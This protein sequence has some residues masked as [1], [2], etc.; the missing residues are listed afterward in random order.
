MLPNFNIEKQFDNKTIVGIDEVGRGPLAGPLVVCAVCFDQNSLVPVPNGINDS[1]L[2]S[3]KKRQIVYDQLIKIVK[4]GIGFVWPAEIDD[5]K[6]TK[7][8]QLAIIRALTDLNLTVDLALIDGNLKYDLPIDYISI[9]KGDRKSIS[10]A[11]ASII[12]KVVRDQYMSEISL[13]YPQYLWHQN[14]GYPTKA[15]LEAISK[16]GI[17][18]KHHRKSFAGVL[19]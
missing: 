10:I 9:I 3:K 5:L 6:L 16:F 15:H 18:I 11:S 8:T 7:A 14:S 17:S 12:A 13:D 2:L 19:S 1:K 4:Y